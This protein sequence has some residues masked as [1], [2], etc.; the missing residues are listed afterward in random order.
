MPAKAIAGS[1]TSAETQCSSSRVAGP[2]DPAWPD[3]TDTESS[4]T[5]AAANPAT[6]IARSSS[7]SRR[8]CSSSASAGSKGATRK[9]RAASRSANSW[10]RA[11]SP[12]HSSASLRVDRLA[13]ASRIAGSRASA[14]S[15][16][17]ARAPQTRPIDMELQRRLARAL[18]PHEGPD[19]LGS[20]GWAQRAGREGEPAGVEGAQ[21]HARDE[22][23]RSLAAMEAEAGLGGRQRRVAM[24]AARLRPGRRRRR[25]HGKG[26]RGRAHRATIL[27][28]ASR[29]SAP[30]ST[31]RARRTARCAQGRRGPRTRPGRSAPAGPARARRAPPGDAARAWRAHPRAP[32]HRHRRAA[33][34]RRGRHLHRRRR[35][36]R[37]R[38][39][40][41]GR[42][43]AP[44]P[45]AGGCRRGRARRRCRARAPNRSRS[46]QRPCRR[47]PRGQGP[48]I[49]R[50]SRGSGFRTRGPC[51]CVPPQPLG[52]T[53]LVTW[54][55]EA[56]RAWPSTRK[57]T[58]TLSP[59]PRGA[60]TWTRNVATAS[61]R[62]VTTACPVPVGA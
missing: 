11:A 29:R 32:R 12:S 15:T 14:V 30:R 7:A 49:P 2:I 34:A 42:P 36:A 23:R 31:R 55:A 20:G 18:R 5:F 37:H 56:P 3:H 28:V 46:R 51:A 6:A 52:D 21:P 39:A 41:R 16:S 40:S 35:R 17:Q 22:L 48:C 8:A 61:G 50:R 38:R 26:G 13:R 60:A 43:A 4:I 47:S 53:K 19:I 58:G 27:R 54:L 1:A 10:P 33:R 25:G 62:A 45:R 44:A 57:V 9:P 24:R 59:R